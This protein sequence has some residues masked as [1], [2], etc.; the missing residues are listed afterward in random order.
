MIICG[1]Y[2]HLIFNILFYSL[3]IFQIFDK[4][5]Q[6]LGIYAAHSPQSLQTFLRLHLLFKN[7]T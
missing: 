3:K 6:K 5:C 7:I 1:E 4:Q 2:F